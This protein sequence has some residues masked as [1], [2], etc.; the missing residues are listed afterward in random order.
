MEGDLQAERLHAAIQAVLETR[1]DSIPAQLDQI[2]NGWR[3]N[4]NQYTKNLDLPFT[5]F[6]NAIQAAQSFI[7][8][9]LGGKSR[10]TW[11]P[12]N[13]KWEGG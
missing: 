11:K 10:G 2:P 7:N 6:D 13:W 1:E 8:P 5:Q 9:V 4:F 3:L 12:E